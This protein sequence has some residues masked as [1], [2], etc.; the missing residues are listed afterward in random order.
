MDEFHYYADRDRGVAWQVPLLTLP[1]ARFLLMSATLGDVDFFAEALTRLNGR[2]TAIVKSVERPVPL[3]FAYSQIPLS[4]TLEKLVAEGKAPVYVVNFTQKDAADS[5]QDFTSL[6]LCT[7]EEKN[8][9]AEAIKGFR[10]TSPYGPELR[11]GSGRASASIT[12]GCCRSTACSSSSS[13]SAACSRSSA[14]PTPSASGINVPIRTV[15]FTRLCKYD[16]QKTAV[17]SARDFHQIAGR[18]GRKGFDDVGFVVAQAPEHVIENLKL[19]DK[20]QGREEVREAQAARAATSRTGT[21]RPSSG[22]SP[23]RPSG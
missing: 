8:A 22:S 21:C 2:P 4:Q 11:S 12:P 19:D 7:R 3:E 1:Q 9:V 6:N 16:G 13:R 23:P 5:A 17:L 20:A 18:A 14:A 10:F 15:L